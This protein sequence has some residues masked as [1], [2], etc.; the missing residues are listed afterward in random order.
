MEK[1]GMAI[2]DIDGQRVRYRFDCRP[3]VRSAP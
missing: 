3:A 1:S 2:A